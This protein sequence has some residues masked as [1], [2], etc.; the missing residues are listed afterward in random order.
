MEKLI[1]KGKKLSGY[2]IDLLKHNLKDKVNII[3]PEAAQSRG[4]QVSFILTK[5]QTKQVRSSCH[6][7]LTTLSKKDFAEK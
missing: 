1:E 3:T 7:F 4:C 5:A 2:L 6:R